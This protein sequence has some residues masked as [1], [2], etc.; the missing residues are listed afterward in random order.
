MGKRGEL[1]GRLTNAVY[2]IT[3]LGFLQDILEDVV[4]LLYAYILHY[5]QG[6]V[7]GNV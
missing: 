2:D 1:V 7:K 5:V 6:A 3:R 4:R